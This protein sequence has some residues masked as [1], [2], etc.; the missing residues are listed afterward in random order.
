VEYSF[1]L[2]SP[3]GLRYLTVQLWDGEV[4]QTVGVLELMGVESTGGVS[5]AH[6]T[7]HGSGLR[8]AIA[9]QPGES[10]GRPFN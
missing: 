2:G 4:L 1:P 10:F 5:A 8:G 3:P 6:S 9:G 7:V